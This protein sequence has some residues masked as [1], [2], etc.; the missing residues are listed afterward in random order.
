MTR[1]PR[2]AIAPW[3]ATEVRTRQE[4]GPAVEAVLALLRDAG[5]PSADQRA[6][7][8]ALEEAL[9]NALVHGHGGARGKAVRL[10]YRVDAGQVSLEVEDDGPGFDPARVPDPRDPANW[11]RPS[12]RGLLLMRAYMTRVEFAGR[13]NRVL[14]CRRRSAA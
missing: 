4:V 2:A 11:E 8:L 6:V 3:R 1:D 5:Y 14:L 12:G 10:H 13:G 7:W 9:V